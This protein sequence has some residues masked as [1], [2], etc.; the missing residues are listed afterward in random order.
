MPYLEIG[1]HVIVA[2]YFAV[3]AVRTRQNMYWLFILFAF[4]MLGSVVYLLA[5]YLPSLRQSRGA[6]VAS[7]TITQLVD[8]NRALREARPDFERAPTGEHRCRTRS[9]GHATPRNTTEIG[10]SAH[11]RC[12]PPH[13][14]VDQPG[15]A[16]AV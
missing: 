16:N 8:P 13:R 11:R 6:H 7:R 5:I 2:M 14:R 4:P 10:C 12:W 9:T 15:S 3:H 1:F